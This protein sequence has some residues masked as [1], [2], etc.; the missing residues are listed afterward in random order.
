MFP[1]GTRPFRYGRNNDNEETQ[2]LALGQTIAQQDKSEDDNEATGSV[3]SG[4]NG[5]ALLDNLE[6]WVFTSR[7]SPLPP[8]DEDSDGSV[9]L[10]YSDDNE[11][12]S[13]KASDNNEGN[14]GITD[15]AII[16]GQ[17]DNAIIDG[18]RDNAI[19]DGQRDNA[20]TNEEI[21]VG[22]KKPV[23]A[24]QII[25]E[26]IENQ[27]TSNRMPSI[28]GWDRK[29]EEFGEML[30]GYESPTSRTIQ[31]DVGLA[32]LMIISAVAENTNRINLAAQQE[33][34]EIM[35]KQAELHR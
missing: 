14:A 30:N 31:V 29:K 19:I 1:L 26:L 20:E 3:K 34:R 4:D 12:E 15:N 23:L 33:Q 24:Q 21:I 28:N 13:V 35:M 27:A 11:T 7:T 2:L 22:T 17:G 5:D 9:P 25:M 18:Q 6:E 32:T 16:D 10:D 8:A